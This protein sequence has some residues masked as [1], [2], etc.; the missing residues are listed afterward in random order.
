[1]SI[2]SQTLR[3]GG[4]SA[5]AMTALLLT[6]GASSAQNEVPPTGGAAVT[7]VQHPDSPG[8]GIDWTDVGSGALAGAALVA[9]AF[10]TSGALRR[11]THQPTPA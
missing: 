9:G 10:A 6:A 11:R 5:V 4:A 8:T 3:L 1:M 2:H 7:T